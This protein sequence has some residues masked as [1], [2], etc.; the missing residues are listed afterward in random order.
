MR[1]CDEEPMFDIACIA[2]T[3]AFFAI[4]IAYTG[5]CDRLAAKP[6]PPKAVS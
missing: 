3:L 5:T 2:A 6:S 4:A 1:A